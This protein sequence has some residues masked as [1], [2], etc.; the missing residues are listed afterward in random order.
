MVDSHGMG[1]W[2]LSISKISGVEPR[3]GFFC[4]D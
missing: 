4:C 1:C 3:E 2:N